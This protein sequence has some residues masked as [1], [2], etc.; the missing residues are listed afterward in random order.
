MHPMRVKA[1]SVALAA[2]TATTT[3]PHRGGQVVA[4]ID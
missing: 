1:E 4:R 2:T 3:T